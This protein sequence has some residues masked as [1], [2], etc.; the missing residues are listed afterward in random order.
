M[1]GQHEFGLGGVGVGGQN[2][3]AGTQ[4]PFPFAVFTQAIFISVDVMLLGV[5]IFFSF[6]YEALLAF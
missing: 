3:V 6:F 5:Y 2:L 1:E 4:G